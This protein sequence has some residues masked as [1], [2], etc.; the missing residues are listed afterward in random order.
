M[1][2]SIDDIDVFVED[3]DDTIVYNSYKYELSK[4]NACMALLE[5]LGPRAPYIDKLFPSLEEIEHE[6]VARH[7]FS[8]ESQEA[9][10]LKFLETHC[11]NAVVEPSK[12]LVEY[13]RELAHYPIRASSYTADDIIFGAEDTLKFKIMQ[14]KELYLVTRGDD[15]VQKA[16]MH[17]LG[18]DKYFKA[19]NIRVTQTNDK[20]ALLEEISAGKDRSRIAIVDNGLSMIN[21]AT[22]LGFLGF[23]VPL[24]RGCR[25]GEK[26]PLGVVDKNQTIPL[27]S[28]IEIKTGA[29]GYRSWNQRVTAGDLPAYLL[30]YDAQ[31]Q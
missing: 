13:F 24:K 19:E 6:I 3:Y 21:A 23:F 31:R 18:I 1:T 16:K 27:E 29:A 14:G 4:G 15:A 20:R 5:F 11:A 22:G 25:D 8:E 28:I 26:D 9:I 10:F 2:L 12:N 17:Y 30:E 7:G